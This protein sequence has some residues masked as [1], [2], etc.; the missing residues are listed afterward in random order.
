MVAVVVVDAAGYMVEVWASVDEVG[1][2]ETA[3]GATAVVARVVGS[4]KGAAAAKG[5]VVEATEV[6][7]EMAM[8]AD[9]VVEA[10]VAAFVAAVALELVT[11]GSAAVAALE[12]VTVGTAA[13][14]AQVREAEVVG[15]GMEVVVAD[16]GTL[17]RP[18]LQRSLA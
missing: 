11:V 6:G 7:E 2:V 5:W 3:K 1:V 10:A 4:A 13:L 12:L 9:T 16:V 8:E 17:H 15:E 18:A 14:G